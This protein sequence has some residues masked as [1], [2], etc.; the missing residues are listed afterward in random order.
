MPRCDSLSGS[1]PPARIIASGAP[2]SA[3]L[4]VGRDRHKRRERLRRTG[5]AVR[6]AGVAVIRD[7]SIE[8]RAPLQHVAGLFV[9][10]YRARLVHETVRHCSI[11]LCGSLVRFSSTANSRFPNS[12]AAALE[13]LGLK[14]RAKDVTPGSNALIELYELEGKMKRHE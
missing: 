4:V 14:R 12:A 10:D 2:S 9:H 7:D 5:R 1:P 8:R 6:F 3:G 13:T 11:L